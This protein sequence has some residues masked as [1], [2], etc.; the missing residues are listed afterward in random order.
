M[1]FSDSFYRSSSRTNSYPSIVEG[2]NFFND[3]E[4]VIVDA[5]PSTYRLLI[6][7]PSTGFYFTIRKSYP[8]NF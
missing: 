2:K 5:T 7:L 1:I 3:E 4:I 8:Q 6:E